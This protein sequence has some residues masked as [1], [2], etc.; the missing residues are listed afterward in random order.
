MKSRT[1]S[2]FPNRGTITRRQFAKGAAAGVMGFPSIIP[3]SARGADGATAPSNRIGIGL[4]GAGNIN[5]GHREVFLAEKDAR[6]LAVCDPITE[7][8]IT[9]RNRINA[10]YGGNVCADYSDF[11]EVLARP[12]IDAVCI[13]VPDHWHAVLGSAAM[14]A[15]KDL[16][17]EKPLTYAVA[18]GRQ[19][20]E[21]A[22]RLGRILQTGL[23]RRSNGRYRYVCE[24]VRNGRIGRLTN[25]E[26]G[27]IGINGGQ[28]VGKQ[29]PA[30]A[31]P[32]G[33]DY[34]LWLGPAPWAPYCP[35]RIIKDYWYHISDY[36]KGFIP[37]N[38]V[39]YVDIAQWGI[40][41]EV[42]PVEVET[43]LSV[44]PPT[45]LIDAVYA[46]RSEI[47]YANGVRMSYSSLGKPHPDG[48]KFVGTEGWIH[49]NV[50][51]AATASAPGILQSVIGPNEIHLYASSEPHRNFLDCIRTRR[52]A[53]ACPEIGHH[54]TTTCNIAEVAARVG[55]KVK[56]DAQKERFIGD[57]MADR[58]LIQPM[59]EPWYM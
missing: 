56:W 42:K 49:I 53:A 11:R 8:R 1:A 35:Q 52:P 55:R 33:F 10:V 19:I 2:S 26:V 7:R 50:S 25:I 28:Q 24:L 4:I 9:Y 47:L 34:E 30:S 17:L 51:G 13:A 16:Y 21:T 5:N 54:A 44:F 12:D 43:P 59:R 45:G 48:I 3:F 36:A 6:L 18:E 29:Y 38:G 57:A 27:I 22:A 20:I 41:D 31:P 14:R 58:L 23:Q 32:E 40:G 15:G 39:H 37:G 46:W